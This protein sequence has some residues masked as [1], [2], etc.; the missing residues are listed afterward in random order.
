[1]KQLLIIYFLVIILPK[2]ISAFE[3]EKRIPESVWEM[4]MQV[5]Y[6]PSYTKAFNGYG[7]EVPLHNLILWDRDWRNSVEGNI[8]RQEER[9]EF[10]IAY[11]LTEI[12][13]IQALIPLVQKTQ[14]SSLNI[15]SF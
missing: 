14:K 4:E 12:W 5:K 6:T 10:R 9:I 15:K 3:S 11:G 1:M 7:Q 2:A 13:M 8:E